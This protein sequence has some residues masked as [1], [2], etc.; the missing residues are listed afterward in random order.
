MIHSVDITLVFEN[1]SSCF[2]DIIS[3]L[4]NNGITLYGVFY[5]YFNIDI[6]ILIISV[7]LCNLPFGTDSEE[8]DD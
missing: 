1:I 8:C 5:S 7:V 6:A 3:W 4:Q 2:R